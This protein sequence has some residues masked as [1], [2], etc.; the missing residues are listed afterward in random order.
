MKGG[1]KMTSKETMIKKIKSILSKLPNKDL[2]KILDLA[3]RALEISKM[4]T[5]EK[6]AVKIIKLNEEIIDYYSPSDGIMEE[7]DNVIENFV[8]KKKIKIKYPTDLV[9][10]MDE[11]A[12]LKLDDL[13]ELKEEVEDYLKEVKEG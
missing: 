5:K 1:D 7:Y 9:R 4:G 3:K 6:I 11:L 13:K 10:E 2:E 12:R 8:R